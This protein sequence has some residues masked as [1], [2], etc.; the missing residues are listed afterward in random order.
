MSPAINAGNNAVITATTDLDGNPRITGSSVDMGAYEYSPPPTMQ[1]IVRADSNPTNAATVTFTV[2]FDMSVSGVDA[3]DFT[4]TTTDGQSSARIANV[5]SSATPTT[6]WTVTVSTT[7][8][9]SGTI[10]LDLVDDDSITNTNT[11]PVALGGSGTGNGNFSS[12]EIYTVDRIVPTVVISTSVSDPTNASTIP[13]TV[14]FSEA[15]T[16]F[17]ATDVLT[18]NATLSN[19]TPVSGSVYTFMLTPL[20][21]GVVTATVGAAVAT[22]AVGNGNAAATLLSRTY[23]GTAP[24]V[25]LSTSVSDP[26]NASTIPV[27]VTFSEAVTGFIATDILTGNATLSNFTPVSGS[28]YTFTLTPLADGVVTTTLNANVATDAAGNSNSAATTFS[29]TYARSSNADLS[30]LMLSTGTLTPTFDAATQDYTATVPFTVTSLT[31]T[32][33]VSDTNATVKVNDTSAVTPVPLIVGST[34][35]TVSVTAQDG[36]TKTYTITVTR[37]AANL[38]HNADL[39]ALTLSSGTLTPT[40]DAATQDYTATVPFTVTKLTVTPTVSDTNATVK[41]NDTSAATPVPL[42]VGSTTVTVSV[43]A[44]DGTTKTYTITVIQ[45]GSADVAITQSYKLEKGTG[46]TAQPNSLAALTNTLTLTITV[47]N[48]G[49]NAVTGVVI[50]DSFPTAAVSTTWRWTC[51][52]AGGGV[53]GTTNGTGN[54]NQTLG[55]LPKDGSVTFVVTGSLLNPNTWRNT[56]S[57]TTPMGV[58]DAITSN[59]SVTVTVSNFVMFVPLIVK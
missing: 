5:S 46:T 1:S 26:T 22:D 43:T 39:S 30:N 32:P 6:T 35:V 9:V 2:T 37:S 51:V 34:T 31:I 53:C 40:F 18:G 17:I 8:L 28:V 59:N 20:A 7:D 24:T 52:G 56:S 42:I 25:V 45:A 19:F 16:G 13:V 3:T 47:R 21:D 33:T 48:N 10:R 50:A 14:T 29:I 41:V 58:F 57:A 49:P 15:V 36:T 11:P 27:T 54:L 55:L 38:A 23:D 4:L 12:G 44:Q